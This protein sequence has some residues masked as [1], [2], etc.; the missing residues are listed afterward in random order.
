MDQH[1][2]KDLLR[3]WTSPGSSGGW[4]WTSRSLAIFS[5]SGF[6]GVES[7]FSGVV[8]LLEGNSLVK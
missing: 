7:V 6:L 4:Y 3:D 1:P 8:F 2:G 5:R